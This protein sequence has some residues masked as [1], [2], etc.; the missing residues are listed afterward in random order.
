[1]R[2]SCLIFVILMLAIG[3][4]VYAEISTGITLSYPMGAARMYGDVYGGSLDPQPLFFGPVVR[5]KYRALYLDTAFK[6]WP[7]GAMFHGNLNIGVCGDLAFLRFGLSVGVDGILM[8]RP[9]SSSILESGWNLKLDIDVLIKRIAIGFSVAFPMDLI[10]NLN[11]YGH[12]LVDPYDELRTYGG[13]VSINVMY[14]FDYISK[15]K[16]K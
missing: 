2:K 15:A 3:E 5:W 12:F 13:L 14:R 6:Y 7:Y 9:L 1:M 4:V 16:I 8:P 10:Q 11:K